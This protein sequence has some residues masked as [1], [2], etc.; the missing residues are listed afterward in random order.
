[1]TYL[2]FFVA[3]QLIRF[4]G[5]GGLVAKSGGQA[6]KTLIPILGELEILKMIERP[7]W[8]IFLIYA[9][10]VGYIM[11]AVMIVEGLQVYKKRSFQDHLLGVLS[12][13]L[14][15]RLVSMDEK[16]KYT[17]PELRGFKGKGRDWSEAIVLPS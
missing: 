12:A 14:Y 17:G 13:G 3:L 1:M 8:W 15:L 9:P 11:Y 7:W 16:I 6:W 4:I 2:I 5:F 10:I